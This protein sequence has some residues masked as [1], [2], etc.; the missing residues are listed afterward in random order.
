[1]ERFYSALDQSEAAAAGTAVAAEDGAAASW[2]GARDVAGFPLEAVAAAA[3]LAA[4]GARLALTTELSGAAREQFRILRTRVLEAIQLRALRILLVTSAAAG[5]GKTTV[6]ATLALQ[7]ASLQQ[8]RVLLIDGDLR[9]AGLSRL[10]QPAG[11][12]GL[13]RVLRGEADW[14]QEVVAIDAWLAVLPASVCAAG[15]AELLS[16]ERLPAL[17]QAVGEQFA[18]VLVDGAPLG[19]VADSQVLARAADAALLVVRAGHTRVGEVERA[20]ALLRPHLVGTVLNG[21]ALA[22]DSY[23]YGYGEERARQRTPAAA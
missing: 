18:L 4:T 7:F 22:R 14:E 13:A 8:G 17:L 21:S 5:E 16:G 3:P 23:G 15:G 20:A 10:L 9:R 1:M 11:G 19:P 12:E 2:E 6:A